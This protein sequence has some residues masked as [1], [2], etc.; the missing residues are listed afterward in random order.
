M[1]LEIPGTCAVLFVYVR[2]L[3]GYHGITCGRVGSS[4][5]YHVFTSPLEAVCQR[6]RYLLYNVYCAKSNQEQFQN[7][8]LKK[9]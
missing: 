1:N 3:S 2:G 5:K 9:K 6:I 7:F 4:G 8:P